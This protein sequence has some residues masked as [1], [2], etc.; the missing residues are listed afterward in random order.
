MISK[1]DLD[2]KIKAL[3][4]NPGVYKYFDKQGNIIYVGKAKNLKK[5]VSSYFVK[6]HQSYKTNVLVKRIKNIEYIVTE[7]END[8][9]LLENILI[10]SLQP[11][12]NVMLKDDKTYPWICIKKE[13]F[14][15]VFY[16]RQKIKDGSEYFGPFTSV[17]TIKTLLNL[18]RQLY[19][20]R[21]CNLNL[22]QENIKN[23][24][25]KVCLEYHLG[26]CL[27]PCIGA[28][29]EETYLQ[30]IAD[31]RKILK[32]DLQQI[33][34]FFTKQM[35]N[36]AANLEFEK[37]A[38][39]KSK[40]G[41][42]ENYK[43]KSSI[44]NTNISD[45]EAFGFA[46]DINSA[47]VSYIRIQSGTVIAAHSVEIR[48]KIDESDEDMI[49][50]AL[51]ELR[52]SLNSDAKTTLLPFKIDFEVENT[53]IEVPK[54][55]DK[56][57]IIEL[58]NRNAKFF[59]LEK[60]KQIENKN[61]EKH[62]QRKLETL[63]K[64]LNLPELPRHIECFDN[65][66][67][68][69]ENPVAACVVFKNARPS[70]TDYRH[71]NIKTVEGS[72]DYAS[73]SEIVYRRYKRLLEEKKEL[74][75]LIIIDGGKGQ[76]S[77]A[78]K[79]LKNLNLENISIISIAEKLE[80]IYFPNDSI[81]LYL[82]KSSESLKLIQFARDEAHRFGLNFHRNKR[83]ASFTVSELENINGIGDKTI[84]LLL[85]KYKS[86]N[87]IKKAKTED[88]EKLIGI[89]KAKLLIDYFK[90]KQNSNE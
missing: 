16:T 15:R 7:T 36:H 8:A 61:P 52:D 6:N 39:I 55:G 32:G 29:D 51:L 4:Q 77:S 35:K 18:I 60:H 43:S 69:G 34:S 46:K 10:K 66:N 84:D 30:W 89:Y 76:L 21:T 54:R 24:K 68:Q 58:A 59:M 2:I 53:K 44:V 50:F 67:I 27:A 17:Y 47:Y 25:F 70:K 9:L 74:P 41:I 56:Y 90:I 71:Y 73:M 81:P 86:V 87:Q 88:L 80:E 48:K 37:A 14:P 20:I 19:P 11:R 79:S 62:I 31:I 26:N 45:T 23:K 57:S 83:S 78:V 72:D 3:P 63:Q 13:S 40:L 82:D 85:T 75:Q 49:L 1:D 65:S 64:D 12:Y 33:Q 42:I 5:R 22:S 28:I 38:E